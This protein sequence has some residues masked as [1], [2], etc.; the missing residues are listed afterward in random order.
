MGKNKKTAKKKKKTKKTKKTKI[1][2]PK[3][4]KKTKKT[5]KKMREPSKLKEKDSRKYIK[6]KISKIQLVNVIYPLVILQI[7]RW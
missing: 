5:K 2:T 3:N 4:T 7:I 1:T 6:L